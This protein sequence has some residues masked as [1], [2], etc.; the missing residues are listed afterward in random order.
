MN[1]YEVLG[2]ARDS[3]RG[4]IRKAYLKLSKLYHPDI[5]EEGDRQFTDIKEAY[6]ILSNA[7][8]R[9]RYDRTGRWDI[10]KVTIEAITEIIHQTMRN[11]IDA[12][13]P[14]GSSDD[15][16]R[17]DVKTKVILSLK[18]SQIEIKDQVFDVTRKIERAQ[19]LSERFKS[20]EL[21][22]PVGVSLLEHRIELEKEKHKLDDAFELS[23]A[24][25]EVFKTYEY[26]VG[27]GTEGH[28]APGPTLRLA[29]RVLS[30]SSF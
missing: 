25:I 26:E 27:P 1:P 10:N 6:D 5:S 24:V 21:T 15:P 4:D 29:G 18:Q 19:R 14:D 7:E 13:R 30:T 11:V 23:E 9:L 12:R 16:T 20:K 17:E 2:V 8:R 28:T 22:D 3:T